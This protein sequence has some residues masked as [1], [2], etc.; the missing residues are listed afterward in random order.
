MEAE[1]PRPSL[2]PAFHFAA[3][4]GWL[5]DP[6]GLAF[7]KGRWHLFFQH[8]PGGLTWGNMHWGHATSPDL[9]SWK[10]GPIALAPDRRGTVFSGCALVLAPGD[11]PLAP[12]EGERLLLCYTAA[13][14]TSLASLGRRFSQCC[15]ISDD[16]LRF[17][18]YARN[19]V[20]R[21]IR[22]TNR[23]PKIVRHGP[24]GT[25]IMALW[26][27]GSEF[28]LLRST[29]LLSWEIA[30]RL[31]MPGSIECPDFFPLAVDGD[32]AREK[33]VFMAADGRYLVGAFDGLRFEAEAGPFVSDSG[34]NFYAPQ[35]FAF[36]AAGGP[37][38]GRRVQLAWMKGGSYPGELFSQ[39]MTVP[40][41]L[42]LVGTPEGPRLARLPVAELRGLVTKTEVSGGL[43]LGPVEATIASGE[44]LDLDLRL[45]V[46]ARFRGR[47]GL[48]ADAGLEVGF[49]FRGLVLLWSPARREL[50]LAGRTVRLAA[51]TT[52][53]LR[54][55]LDRSSLEVFAMDGLVSLSSCF[56]PRADRGISA[57]ARGAA[58]S[59]ECPVFLERVESRSL[60]TVMPG[61]GDIG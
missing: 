47:A 23:D 42:G 21:P 46:E 29:D 51:G 24:T 31:E 20:I 12:A 9:F 28:A 16:G 25:W 27:R 17:A 13:G 19:P 18:K 55:L 50:T 30:Q 6:N 7:F 37:G 15:A 43:A 36:A 40:V 59:E 14:S 41:E 52:L 4:A 34:P 54:A 2:R 33:W 44:A 38:G 32:P 61:R 56:V 3:A 45:R 5:N 10:E 48:C 11:G 8:N 26:L 58:G 60:R 39:Q 49:D 35:T 57:Y 53:A 22:A 1:V